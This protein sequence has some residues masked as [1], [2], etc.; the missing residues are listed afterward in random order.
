MYKTISWI[1]RLCVNLVD[2]KNFVFDSTSNPQG[3]LV[4]QITLGSVKTQKPPQASTMEFVS[5]ELGQG[6]VSGVLIGSLSILLILPVWC[7]QVVNR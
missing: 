1:Q 7:E 3:A 2:A 5:I 6:L 4:T